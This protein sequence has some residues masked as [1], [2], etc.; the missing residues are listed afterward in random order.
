MIHL[1]FPDSL[2]LNHIVQMILIVDK[3]NIFPTNEICLIHLKVA[4][5]IS[6]LL[7]CSLWRNVR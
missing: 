5:V 3:F 7:L 2:E 1:S 6:S 4:S